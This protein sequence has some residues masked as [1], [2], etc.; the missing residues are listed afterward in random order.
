[1]KRIRKTFRLWLLGCLFI[2]A[3]AG[4]GG[5][6]GEKVPIPTGPVYQPI[7]VMDDFNDPNSGWPIVVVGGARIGYSNGE[8]FVNIDYSSNFIACMKFPHKLKGDLIMAL[9]VKNQRPDKKNA[10]GGLFFNVDLSG[11]DRN[12]YTFT[13]KPGFQKFYIHRSYPGNTRLHEYQLLA[14]QVSA[15]YIDGRDYAVNRLKVVIEGNDA[16]FYINEHQVYQCTLDWFSEG[17]QV[18]LY[19]TNE[20]DNPVSLYFDNFYLKGTEIIE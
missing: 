10:I 15:P 7:E 12:I 3:V 19:A 20:D 14:S 17:Q 16:T 11:D 18:G 13:L 6:G 4:C 2:I 9:D 1:M 8:Y 5:G